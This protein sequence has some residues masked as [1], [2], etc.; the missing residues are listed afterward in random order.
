[1]ALDIIIL[2]VLVAGFSISIALLFGIKAKIR[3]NE[4]IVRELQDLRKGLESE[5]RFQAKEIRN[6]T[7][8]IMEK[9]R[10]LM[11]ES[12]DRNMSVFRDFQSERFSSM[13]KM[14]HNLI[15]DTESKLESIRMTVSEKLDK[16]LGERLGRSFDM[17]GKQLAEVQKGLGEMQALA[18]DVGGL[19]KVL[20]NVKIRGGIGEIQLSMILEQILAP[21]Q[22]AANVKT[23]AASADFVE[24]AVRL[25]GKNDMADCVWLPIDAKFP[26]D[27]F[28]NLQNA[29]ESCDNALVEREQRIFEQ[30]VLKMARDIHD[31]YI[32]PPH[33]TDFGIMFLPFE[34]IYSEV[35]R[36]ASLLERLQ[37]EYK[38]IATGPTTLAAILN[39]LQLGFRT[40]AIEKRS[41]EVWNVLGAVKKEFGKFGELLA[42]AQNN[43]QGGLNQLDELV[44]TRTRA[45]N[46][47]L[48]EVETNDD[49]SLLD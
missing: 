46:R 45:I 43:I 22:Y 49:I 7:S 2:A 37:V 5:L 27:V 29:Y 19:K 9:E 15:R 17:V 38:V 18:N 1:M 16:T 39:S 24:F 40:L 26:K 11:Q 25:P 14:Q 23:K 31:K 6:E 8:S 12:Y 20:G 33:T 34:G 44:G 35:A 30:A 48:R 4:S 47:K 13:E 10:R 3:D 41:S 32:D 21:E 28:E 36:R 42:K